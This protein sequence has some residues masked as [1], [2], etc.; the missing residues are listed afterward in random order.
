[1]TWGRSHEGKVG[2]EIFDEQLLCNCESWLPDGMRFIGL[3]CSVNPPPSFWANK[4]PSA[5]PQDCKIRAA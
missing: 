5:K 4:A 3:I 2:Q 1:M